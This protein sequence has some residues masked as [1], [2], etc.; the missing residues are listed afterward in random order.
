MDLFSQICI[1]IKIKKKKTALTDFC[2]DWSLNLNF[3]LFKNKL[4]DSK[5]QRQDFTILETRE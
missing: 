1:Q 2:Q 3:E 5:A 4:H